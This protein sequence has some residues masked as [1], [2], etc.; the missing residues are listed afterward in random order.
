MSDCIEKIKFVESFNK[1][2]SL[3]LFSN[4][5]STGLFDL[6]RIPNVICLHLT[7]PNKF[8][9]LKGN[10]IF[11]WNDIESYHAIIIKTIK[12]IPGLDFIYDLE[13]EEYILDFAAEKV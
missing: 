4:K 2:V 13:R 10:R 1:G 11:L 3:V 8:N 5:A 6:Y 12:T 7:K 9:G